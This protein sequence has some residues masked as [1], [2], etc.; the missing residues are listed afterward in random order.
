MASGDPLSDLRGR[1][2]RVVEEEFASYEPRAYTDDK[3]LR[4]VIW[5]MVSILPHELCLLDSPL[6]QRLRGVY[7]TS[8]ALLTYPCSVHSRFEHSVGTLAIADRVV[9]AL[10]RKS[11]IQVPEEDRLEVRIAALLHDWTHGPLSHT[12]ESVYGTDAIF[13]EIKNQYRD[14]FNAAAPSEI[15]TYCLLTSEPFQKLWNK[16]IDRC[17]DRPEFTYLK[18]CDPW[19][20]AT[21]IIGADTNE[22]RPGAAPGLGR[23]YLRQL[24]NGPFDVD[25]L[26]YIAR[27][28]YFTGLALEVDV[29][30]LLWVLD[31]IDVDAGNNQK[32]KALCVAAS[33]AMILEQILF[34]KMQLFSSVYHHPKVR[35]SH[36][37]AVR[38]MKAMKEADVRFNGLTLS[39]PATFMTLNDYDILH[40]CFASNGNG[41]ESLDLA[42]SLSRDIRERTL[43]MRALVLT[44][45]GWGEDAGQPSEDDR[46]GW[47][48]F[49]KESGQPEGFEIELATSVGIPASDVWVDVPSPVNLQTTGQEGIV[50][51]SSSNFLPVQRMFPIAGWL[52]AYQSY[53][54][55]AYIFAKSKRSDIA[56]KARAILADRGVRTNDLTMKLA[57]VEF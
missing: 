7:Q 51:F 40:P 53:R 54:R 19:R 5:G 44:H 22:E 26:D 30:R 6:F 4:D 1:V 41:G 11:Y 52:S 8:L 27:D 23:R 17:R 43:P 3:I 49:M 36:Q 50:K 25:K 13:T 2:A 12:A 56:R 46:V 57:K 24:V 15:L 55:T 48:D 18:V 47:E 20:I 9:H 21:M 38:L 34:A 39:D 14:T 16:I 45:P 35:V 29:D 37:A 28:G 32:A 42:V 31:T 33:G 10:R